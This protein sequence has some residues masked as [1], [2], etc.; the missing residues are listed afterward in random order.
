MSATIAQVCLLRGHPADALRVAQVLPPSSPQRV[1][2]LM[3]VGS[4]VDRMFK[5]NPE[6]QRVLVE[7]AN[8]SM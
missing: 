8:E 4:S 1:G 6:V 5:A 7:M 2:V 3:S